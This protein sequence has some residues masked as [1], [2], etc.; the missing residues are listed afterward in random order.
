[1]DI[2]AGSWPAPQDS[3][4]GGIEIGIVIPAH[5][6]PGFLA[7]ALEAVLSQRA[8]GGG[9]PRLAAVVVDDGCPFAQTRE[10]GLAFARRHPDR[11]FYLRRAN[12]GLSAARNTGIDFVLRA[13]PGCRA[14]Y[15]LDADNRLHPDFLARAL[16]LLEESPAEVGW[17]YPDFDFFGF[18]ENYSA[19]GA[20]SALLHQLENHCE[21]GSLI[22][23]A[24][25]EAGL[26]Y[27]ETMRDGFEDWDFW[28]RASHRGFRG[29]HLPR[30][31][32]LY[33]KRAESMLAGSER[34]RAALLA[35]MRGRYGA[36]QRARALLRLEAAE[37]PRFALHLAGEEAVAFLLDP[38][39]EPAER[40]DWPRA[41]ARLA[42]SFRSPQAVHAPPVC[43]FAEAGTLARLAEAGLLR[44]VFHHAMLALREAALV[45]VSLEAEPDGGLA[46]AA[47]APGAE[48]APLLFARSRLL[49][50]WALDPEPDGLERALEAAPAGMAGFRVGLPEPVTGGGEAPPPALPLL[51]AAA[52]G[53]RDLVRRRSAMPADWRAEWRRPRAQALEAYP[54]LAGCGPPLPYLA[55]ED[56]RDIAFLLPLFAFGGV[57]KVVF[58]YAAVLRRRGWRPHLFITGARRIQPMPGHA[59]VFES[60]NFF[61]G[62]SIEGGDYDRLHLGACVSGFALWKDTRD[63]VGLL[64]GMDVV[65]NTH[66]L[67]GHGLMQALRGQ[68]VRTWLGLHLVERGPFGQPLGNPHIALAYEGAYDGVVVISDQLRDWCVGQAV[69]AG[70]IVRVLNAPSYEPVPGRPAE[71]MAA[72]AARPAEAPLRLLY[73]GRLD[74]Q[75]GLERLRDIILRTRGPRFAWRLAGQAVLGDSAL[76]LGQTGIA[77]EPP[78]MD[79]AGL[80]ALYAWADVVLLPSRFEGVPL[81]VLEAQRFGCVVVATDVGAVPEI[82]EDGRDG[83]LLRTDRGEAAVVEDAVALLERLAAAPALRRAVGEAAAARVSAANWERN[84]AEWLARL[85]LPLELPL[86]IPPGPAA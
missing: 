72:R 78:A 38:A 67:G 46:L 80:D 41:H 53:L 17:V 63:A 84:M 49:E 47:A 85:E 27:D 60:L 2:A 54:E 1:M 51:R 28:L 79:A 65:V 30:A 69:P 39:A 40:L 7:E 48:A 44:T 18:A 59:A 68:G 3:R 20:Y 37:A 66:A 76:D 86:E 15:P 8:P 21:A 10:T 64:A 77:V 45:T 25:F 11:I 33:R 50:D 34:R 22:R 58:N 9:A 61:P 36:A 82:I 56:G 32:F 71:A 4:P 35:T 24:V 29:R 43:V 42:E 23:R 81:T 73:L 70:K 57:E 19:R 5:R 14:L 16:A 13:W 75:K 12:G 26:R 62:E 6:Q 52:A 83:F 31:G 74:A 55:P